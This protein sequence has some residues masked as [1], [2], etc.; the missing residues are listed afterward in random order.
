MQLIADVTAVTVNE[1]RHIVSD[2]A[3]AVDG[4]KIVEVGKA[5]VLRTKYAHATVIDGK[6]MVAIPGL[7]DT[8]GH[9]D[10]SLL[11]GL[12]DAM[13][14]MPFLDDVIGPYLAGRDPGDAVTAYT[15][16]GLEMIK[17]GTTCFVS[18]NVDPRDDF[19][20]LTGAIGRL[21]LR[22][23]LA[24]FVVPRD[25]P[26]SPEAARVVMDE[27]VADVRRWNGAEGGLAQMW[28]GAAVP[29]RPGEPYTPRYHEEMGARAK[30]LGIGIVYHFCSE[31][32]D[33]FYFDNQFG[34][35]P[36]EWARQHHLTGPN[37][38][39]IGGAWMTP[40]EIRIMAETGTPLVHSPVANMKMA[41]G[42]LP[43]PDVLEA[44]VTVS[45]G[46]DGALN[47]NTHDMFAE[48]KTACLLQNA[49]RHRAG[50][51]SPYT[52]FEMATINGAKAIGRAHDLGSLE[53]GKLA[54]IVLVDL[55]R[56]HTVPV[57]D[58]V[59]NLVFA[60]NASNVDTVMINGRIVVKDGKVPGLDEAA[61]Y[62]KAQ[63]IAQR[64]V[65][66]LKLTTRSTWPQI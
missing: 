6:G 62:A 1:K 10:Q 28:F 14:W 58:V 63:E 8:H 12:G 18:P 34:M 44:G 36:T 46:T 47:N 60:A 43:L 11:R 49:V 38:L 52:A 65:D 66:D 39:P 19:V 35:R 37:I 45:I 50:T 30:D 4:A 22:A 41:T 5:S 54:D 2:A 25:E 40:R 31:I 53:A 29:R 23:V 24:R 15:L 20:A 55:K 9:A 51:L 61:L 48:M 21:G 32:E 17:G 59:S 16:S 57:F 27:A 3:I 26:D 7:I 13:H 64:L 56:A 42:I 33:S